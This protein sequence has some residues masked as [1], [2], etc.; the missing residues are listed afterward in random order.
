MIR[1]FTKKRSVAFNPTVRPWR[2]IHSFPYRSWESKCHVSCRYL[3][4]QDP[5]IPWTFALQ[6]TLS[7]SEVNFT[8]AFPFGKVSKSNPS[9]CWELWFYGSWDTSSSDTLNRHEFTAKFG[10]EF[11]PCT[12]RIIPFSM[13]LIT[14]VSKFPKWGYSPYKWPKWLIN[15]GY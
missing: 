11:T 7:K 5:L 15:G 2:Y 6:K 14:M 9:I 10:G 1:P 4:R 12:W 13:W 3:S 8:N